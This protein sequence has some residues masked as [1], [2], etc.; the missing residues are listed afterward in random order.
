MSLFDVR[1][2]LEVFREIE[3]LAEA[4]I[5]PEQ[6]GHEVRKKLPAIKEAR[7]FLEMEKYAMA[8]AVEQKKMHENQKRTFVE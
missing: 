2:H 6:L 5:P 3:Q 8:N 7:K 1:V 4:H